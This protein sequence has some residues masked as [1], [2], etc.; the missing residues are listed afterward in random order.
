MASSNVFLKA[1]RNLF[2]LRDF[3]YVLQLEEYET[4]PYFKS[5]LR[6]WMRRGIERRDVLKFTSRI[7]ATASLAVVLQISFALY[8][9]TESSFFAMLVGIIFA[10]FCTPL[11]VGIAHLILLPFAVLQKELIQKR[12][13]EYFTRMGK[14]TKVIAIAG[15]FGKTTTRH[16]LY[17]LLKESYKTQIMP[18]NINTTMGIAHWLLTSFQPPTQILLIEMD[19]YHPG[20]IAASCRMV[21]PDIAILTSIGDQHLVRFGDSKT[22]TLAMQEVFARAKPDALRIC[23]SEVARKLESAGYAFDLTIIDDGN[24]YQGIAYQTSL[25][26]SAAH[27]L[28]FALTVAAHFKIPS[29]FILD[30]VK[31]LRSPDRRQQLGSM[32][33]YDAIDDSYNISET[34]ARAGIA[35]ARELAKRSGKKL[36]VLTAGISELSPADAKIVNE[37][38]GT[39]LSKHADAAV[40]LTSIYHS[41]LVKGISRRIP[42]LDAANLS[43]A[44]AAMKTAFPPENHVLLV[45]PEMTDLSY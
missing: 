5:A 44:V 42:T 35:A 10:A 28:R 30:I 17:E 33:G 11:F 4:L 41:A 15:S 29:R 3:L 36:L 40:L 9:S 23:D 22:L 20:E 27:D 19:A 45:Q 43:Q 25:S 6:M 39:Y 8:I 26:A 7:K 32:Y 24:E 16:F 12:A 1:W 18:G 2:P 34:T 38:Y 31:T 14:N 37:R 13:R 21:S